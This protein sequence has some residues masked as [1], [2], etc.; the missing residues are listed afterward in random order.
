MS[1]LSPPYSVISTCSDVKLSL[2]VLLYKMTVVL[3]VCTVQVTLLHLSR[4]ALPGYW[5]MCFIP[6]GQGGSLD[7]LGEEIGV[8]GP[9]LYSIFQEMVLEGPVLL[10]QYV[11]VTR[12][13]GSKVALG[14]SLTQPC[15]TYRF[16]RIEVRTSSQGR[17]Y[18]V[19]TQEEEEK[20]EAEFHQIL[21]ERRAK[22]LSEE[23]ERQEDEEEK[24]LEDEEEDDD[25]DEDEEEGPKE[26]KKEEKKEEDREDSGGEEAGPGKRRRMVKQ[27]RSGNS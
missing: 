3:V 27:R 6:R 17:V 23:E 24:K 7:W 11:T 15:T 13:D 26:E 4:V 19:A 1:S 14:P 8:A 21:V 16:E 25:R 5:P 9:S 12:G 2:L 18:A 10:P 20:D 22:H